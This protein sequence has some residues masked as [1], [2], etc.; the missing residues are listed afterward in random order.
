MRT[1]AE[2]PLMST[3]SSKDGQEV[4]DCLFSAGLHAGRSADSPT[5]GQNLAMSYEP[6]MNSHI[7]NPV[8]FEQSAGVLVQPRLYWLA[9]NE[10]PPKVCQK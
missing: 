6:R 7:H 8:R 9:L 1:T 2:L 3:A 5:K 4:P 10:S